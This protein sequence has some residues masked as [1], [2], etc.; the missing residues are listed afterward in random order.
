MYQKPEVGKKGQLQRKGVH[1]MIRNNLKRKSTSS[2]SSSSS[3]KGAKGSQRKK[4]R[5]GESKSSSSSSSSK[6]VV[7]TSNTKGKK[8]PRA[9][10]SNIRRRWTQTEDAILLKAYDDWIQTYFL[11]ESDPI[12]STASSIPSSSSSSSSSSASAQ[13]LHVNEEAERDTTEKEKERE[14]KTGDREDEKQGV[15]TTDVKRDVTGRDFGTYSLSI[16]I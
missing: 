1:K 13:V 16:Y 3:S 12:P 6:D 9:K 10:G 5:K 4:A 15:D 14:I 7:G 11:T 2:S 8:K